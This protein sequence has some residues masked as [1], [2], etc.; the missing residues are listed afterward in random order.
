M[1]HCI[2]YGC[3]CEAIGARVSEQ[4]VSVG[5]ADSEFSTGAAHP[6]PTRL[7]KVSLKVSLKVF[8][9]EVG[10]LAGN[11]GAIRRIICGE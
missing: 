6:F 5:R 10:G 2:T 9:C 7:L 4:W 8:C 11:P 3:E 1:N